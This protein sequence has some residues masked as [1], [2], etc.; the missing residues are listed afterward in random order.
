[1]QKPRPLPGVA[2][3]T[4]SPVGPSTRVHA[5]RGVGR[6]RRR[7]GGVILLPR[8]VAPVQDPGDAVG[9]HA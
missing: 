9:V 8:Q 6:W 7:R 4:R 3:A 5:R 1:M 2:T